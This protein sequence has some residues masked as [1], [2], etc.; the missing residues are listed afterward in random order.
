[1]TDRDK[2]I[3][4]FRLLGLYRRTAQ[5]GQEYL[6][7][8]FSKTLRMVLFPNGRKKPGDAL[9]PDFIAYLIPSLWRVPQKHEKPPEPGHDI[10]PLD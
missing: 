10:P 3:R 9:A 7:G 8:E 2:P 4:G 5:N 1:M 6:S